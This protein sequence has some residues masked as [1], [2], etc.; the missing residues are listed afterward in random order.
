MLLLLCVAKGHSFSYKT[1]ATNQHMNQEKTATVSCSYKEANE[2]KDKLRKIQYAVTDVIATTQQIKNKNSEAKQK[3]YAAASYTNLPAVLHLHIAAMI[4]CF[5][6]VSNK[7]L[8]HF[9]SFTPTLCMS[10]R[11]TDKKIYAKYFLFLLLYLYVNENK[12]FTFTQQ[13]P[14]KMSTI[15]FCYVFFANQKNENENKGYGPWEK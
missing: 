11:T 4:N 3:E 6:Y 14:V 10:M 2:T 13:F 9:F 5:R 8:C 12:Y 1:L 15:C 7:I